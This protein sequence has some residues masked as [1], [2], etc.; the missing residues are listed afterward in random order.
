MFCGRCGNALSQGARF[1]P[2]CGLAVAPPPAQASHPPAQ[3]PSPPAQVHR[4]PGPHSPPQS[5]HPGNA[6]FPPPAS[7]APQ[8]YFAASPRP[9]H[10][11]PQPGQAYPQPAQAVPQPGYALPQ[12]GHPIPPRGYPQAVAPPGPRP[13]PFGRPHSPA[14][15]TTAAVLIPGAGQAYNG[16]FFKG[17]MVLLLSPLLLP[18]FLGIWDAHHQAGKTLRTGRRTGRGGLG[19]ILIQAMLAADALLLAIIILTG[20]G[21]FP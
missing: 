16:Q 6:H 4:P 5:A 21:V 7:H 9:V 20:T 1:C 18:Y 11:P 12:A 3:A 15:A 2:K 13:G 19:W 10:V 8:P 14:V 17:L